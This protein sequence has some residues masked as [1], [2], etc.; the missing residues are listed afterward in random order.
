MESR[1][2]YRNRVHFLIVHPL[3]GNVDIV[4]VDS[5]A[6]IRE[7][8]FPWRIHNCQK[9]ELSE[10]CFRD[11]FSL[12]FYITLLNQK[13]SQLGYFCAATASATATISQQFWC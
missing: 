13:G 7:A 9:Q 10:K 6:C 4:Q 2:G 1:F 8:Y 11:S 12:S 3:F 5:Y